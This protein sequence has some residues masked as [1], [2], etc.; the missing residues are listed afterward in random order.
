MNILKSLLLVLLVIAFAYAAPPQWTS[1]GTASDH[2]T[3]DNVVV[4]PST[5]VKGEL[6]IV[7]ATGTLN[8]EVTAGNVHV[9]VKYG[10]ITLINQNVDFC[11]SENPVPC[12]VPAGTYTHTVNATIP[13]NAPSGTYKANIVATD[14]NSQEIACIDVTL[15]L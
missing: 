2:F 8:E 6:V 10:F 14:Q 7:S 9:T 5:P 3:I 4:T 12:P 15:N 13:A 1:C 11:S